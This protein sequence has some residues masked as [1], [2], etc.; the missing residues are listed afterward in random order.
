MHGAI[1]SGDEAVG[2]RNATY[3]SQLV[4]GSHF[5]AAG[6]PRREG[7][8]LG[9][10]PDAATAG[11]LSLRRPGRVRL[12]DDRRGVE[13]EPAAERRGRPDEHADDALHLARRGIGG[14]RTNHDR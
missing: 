5:F 10:L 1:S 13:P 11:R 14:H 8:R 6:D 4:N 3:V 7:E 9:T 12:P 2:V